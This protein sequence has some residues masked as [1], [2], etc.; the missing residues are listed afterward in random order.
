MR[1][2]SSGTNLASIHRREAGELL[3]DDHEIP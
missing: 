2:M 3:A 1:V